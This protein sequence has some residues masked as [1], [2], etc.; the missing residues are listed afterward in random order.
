MWGCGSSKH[1]S[2]FGVS[3]EMLPSESKTVHHYS[4]ILLVRCH[5]RWFLRQLLCFLS[6][7]SGSIARYGRPT[8]G[9]PAR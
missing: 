9:Q 7:Q 4:Y 2:V 6:H 1:P 5:L 3:V 8:L